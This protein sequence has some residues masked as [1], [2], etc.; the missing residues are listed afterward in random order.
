MGCCGPRAMPRTPERRKELP[1]EVS[2]VLFWGP[3]V[4]AHEVPSCPPQSSR[5][6]NHPAGPGSKSLGL[7]PRHQRERGSP[8][9]DTCAAGPKFLSWA[10]NLG[11]SPSEPLRFLPQQMLGKLDSS[12]LLSGA[13][14]AEPGVL[15]SSCHGHLDHQQL[16]KGLTVH[17][18]ASCVLLWRGGS[19]AE[20]VWGTQISSHFVCL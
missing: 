1:L 5:A 16:G 13:H 6:Q 19:P 12:T 15:C 9:S 14:E 2:A 18:G 11:L 7:D 17:L 4:N 20:H 10:L 8:A 3:A